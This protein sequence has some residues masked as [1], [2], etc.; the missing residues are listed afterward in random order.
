M[1]LTAS[2]SGN[3]IKKASAALDTYL[4]EAG[5]WTGAAVNGSAPSA[6]GNPLGQFEAG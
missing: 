3:R 2:S 6:A 1:P 4:C 5:R